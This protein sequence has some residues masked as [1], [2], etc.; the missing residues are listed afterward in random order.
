MV[1]ETT[2][3]WSVLT[4][5]TVAFACNFAVWTMFSII[6]LKIKEELGLSDTE[7]GILIATPILTGSITR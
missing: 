3:Q 1:S 2:K 4:M 5:N 7:F 6:G